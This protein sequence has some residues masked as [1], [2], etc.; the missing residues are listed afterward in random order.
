MVAEGNQRKVTIIAITV[1]F[2]R[3]NGLSQHTS[4]NAIR[5]KRTMSFGLGKNRARPSSAAGKLLKLT[6]IISDQL[7]APPFVKVRG[8]ICLT[9]C[10]IMMRSR[11]R[12]AV[13]SHEHLALSKN[14]AEYFEGAKAQRLRSAITVAFVSAGTGKRGLDQRVN[15][16]ML[17]VIAPNPPSPRETRAE[18]AV[19]TYLRQCTTNR[20][21]LGSLKGE[22]EEVGAMVKER[23]Q[24]VFEIKETLHG[25]LGSFYDQLSLSTSQQPFTTMDTS[26][27]ILMNTSV[28][29]YTSYN[30]SKMAKGSEGVPAD[31]R[32]HVERLL[33]RLDFNN[34]F[35]NPRSIAK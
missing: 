13:R 15:Q 20:P 11:S 33:L 2:P 26:K 21:S 30:V 19:V 25:L 10:L 7:E 29:N 4:T 24:I 3:R 16:S 9:R 14:R 32:R 12:E 28:A 5:A 6:N 1:P 22:D 18:T 31:V 23:H 34:G 27:S 17:L 8:I 35:S